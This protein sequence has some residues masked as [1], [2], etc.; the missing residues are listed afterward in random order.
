MRRSPKYISGVQSKMAATIVDD[1]DI[2]YGDIQVVWG[3][4]LEIAESDGVVAL[5]GPNGAGKTTIL[6]A[7]SG[8]LDLKGGT[9]TVFGDDV[10]D[11]STDE[12]VNRG[13][14]HV[15]EG[16]NL[17][18]GMSVRENLEMGAYP[19]HAREF[20][21]ETMEDVFDL[22]PVLEEKRGQAAENL[23]GGQQQ[24]LAIGRGLMARPKV[25]ALDEPSTGLAPQIV[26]DVFD[27]IGELSEDLTV[28]LVEQHVN[29]A[30]RLADRAYVL[31]NGRIATEGPGE[32]LL[33]DEHVKEAY[34]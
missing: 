30:L 27:T 29:H 31:E 20:R 17:F 32:E 25:L 6:K 10:T 3:V 12:I 19:K 4:S 9:I 34:L 23:S 2:A 24:M 22:F 16:R 11:L 18:P 1:V 33:R 21:E 5:I 28:F 14:V 13:F 26:Q 8:L 15:S 7:M